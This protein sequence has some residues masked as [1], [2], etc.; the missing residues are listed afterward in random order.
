MSMALLA[1]SHTSKSPLQLQSPPLF[2]PVFPSAVF[3]PDGDVHHGRTPTAYV[4]LTLSSAWMTTFLTAVERVNIRVDES[5]SSRIR[6]ASSGVVEAVSG[7]VIH[8]VISAIRPVQRSLTHI[9]NPFRGDM[10]L[11]TG[12]SEEERFCGYL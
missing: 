12:N 6:L 9:Q 5:A 8:I 11:G 10:H 7:I 2:P 1:H 3:P 4:S